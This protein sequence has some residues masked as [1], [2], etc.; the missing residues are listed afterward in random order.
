MLRGALFDGADLRGVTFA[1]CDLTNADLQGANLRGAS[2]HFADL[3]DARLEGADMTDLDFGYA[4]IGGWID[5]FTTLPDSGTGD[6]C[7]LEGD[8][9]DCWR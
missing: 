9:L 2:L 8:R 1:R 7:T 5:A 6:S 3:V 4:R